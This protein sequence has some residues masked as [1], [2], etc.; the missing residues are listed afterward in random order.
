MNTAQI[1][2]IINDCLDGVER[3]KVGEVFIKDE[4][5]NIR[6]DQFGSPICS[7]VAFNVFMTVLGCYFPKNFT[8]EFKTDV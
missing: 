4:N 3:S 5:G 7:I 2:L 6:R 8:T 1:A